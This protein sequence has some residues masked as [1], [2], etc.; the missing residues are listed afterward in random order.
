MSAR[1]ILQFSMVCS[2]LVTIKTIIA[3]IKPDAILCLKRYVT[4]YLVKSSNFR[5]FLIYYK[6]GNSELLIRVEN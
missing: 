4:Q 5:I 3:T 2:E 1:C 6:I